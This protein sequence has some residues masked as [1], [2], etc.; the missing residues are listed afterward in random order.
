MNKKFKKSLRE[1]I[2]EDFQNLDEQKLE[3]FFNKFISDKSSSF[4]KYYNKTVLNKEKIDF[5][6]FISSK[7]WA[8]RGM[9][10]ETVEYFNKNYDILKEEILKKR[11]ILKF[12]K[13]HC[14]RKRK[15]GRIR[16]EGSFCS[17]LFHTF[18]PHEF[19]PVDSHIRE[20]FGLND[21]N[22]INDVL[23]VRERYQQFIKENPELIKEI[24][25]TLSKDKFSELRIKE[26]SDIRILDMYYWFKEYSR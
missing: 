4:I 26:L 21:E 25:K 12:F 1:T 18:L 8:V 14:Y 20:H 2:E 23:L 11:D 5:K 15:D 9:S 7:N 22:F 6:E 16:R 17:K 24:R 10:R 13:T 19:P 3:A